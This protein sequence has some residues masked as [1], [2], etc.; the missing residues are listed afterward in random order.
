MSKVVLKLLGSLDIKEMSHK[1]SHTVNLIFW[2]VLLFINSLNF[3][4]H[5]ATNS[6]NI[7]IIFHALNHFDERPFFRRKPNVKQNC[8][9]G[10][11]LFAKPIEEPVMRR[12]FAPIPILYNHEKV[13]VRILIFFFNYFVQLAPADRFIRVY[14]I[15]ERADQ[16]E[17]L[18][19]FDILS[20]KSFSL[21]ESILDQR[22]TEL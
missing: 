11:E 10:F 21:T 16:S 6:S 18:P 13:Y 14:S 9:L 1:Q 4:S 19:S 3:Q 20:A 12:K 8:I 17:V 2:N 5:I 22:S 15:P 7:T